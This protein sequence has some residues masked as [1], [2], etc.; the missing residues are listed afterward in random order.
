[1]LVVGLTGGVQDAIVYDGFG[2]ITSET[3]PAARGELGFQGGRADV[4]TGNWM[5]GG[6]EEDPVTRDWTTQ[7]TWGLGPDSN[8]Y[9]YVGNEPTNATD[10]TGHE[11]FFEGT[12]REVPGLVSGRD[13]TTGAQA[14]GVT[15]IAGAEPGGIWVV[16]L[17]PGGVAA[18]KTLFDQQQAGSF[19]YDYYQ[20]LV[21]PNVYKIV[22]VN[23][24]KLEISDYPPSEMNS[25]G[26]APPRPG[27]RNRGG[28]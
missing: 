23:G 13:K 9:R 7:D 28:V 15:S 20:A 25:T 16:T 14:V 8:P 27:Q 26:V 17:P 18:A 22:R 24:N 12:D 10:P 19:G 3:N 21:D 5:Y 2:T 1:M 4:A 6:R 11:L